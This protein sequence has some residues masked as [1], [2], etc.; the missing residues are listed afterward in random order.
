M[1]TV[2]AFRQSIHDRMSCETGYKLVEIDG[3]KP[4]STSQSYRGTDCHEIL[5][6][7]AR[8]C[9]QKRIK[10]DFMFL[11]SLLDSATEEVVSIMETCKDNIE[12]DWE[13]FFAAEISM[14]LDV[15]FQPTY[16]YDHDGNILPVDVIWGFPGSGKEPAYCAIL[17][18]IYIMPGGRVARIRDYKSHPR[19]FSAD[20]IQGKLYSLMLFMHLPELNEVEFGLQFIR[21]AHKTE[22]HKYLRA[23]VPQMMEDIR[24]ER[25]RQIGIHDKVL[26]NEPL[27]THGGSHCVYCPCVLDPVHIPCPIE[28]LNPMT[29]LTPA[30]RLNWRLVHDVMSRTN[31]Q[32]M[33][34]YVDASGQEIRSQDAN[35]KSYTFGPVPKEKT[36]Y[37]L[38]ADDGN[39]GFTLPIVDALL[40]W[41]NAYPEDLQP[42]RKDQRPWFLNLRIGSTQLKQYLKAKK[43]EIIDNR[44]KD[45]ATVETKVENRIHAGCRGR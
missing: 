5:A 2:P 21:Y 25:S 32:A 38:F 17:D 44:I 34:Q 36:T 22:T 43:R 26:N 37:P 42:K 3:I 16:S 41:Q 29:N 27:R 6:P 35:G 28:R 33:A 24:R 40:D 31:N 4:P 1:A 14:G 15:D 19:P 23:D 7:Y 12:I 39:G 10:A 13:N 18:T 45:L 11:D 8:H 9:A 20:T 30:E